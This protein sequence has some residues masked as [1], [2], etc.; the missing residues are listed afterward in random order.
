MTLFRPPILADAADVMHSISTAIPT[1]AV[2]RLRDLG[3]RERRSPRQQAAV[4]V[5]AALERDAVNSTVRAQSAPRTTPR[6]MDTPE[7]TR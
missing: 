2:D 7:R 6:L 1:E 4:L 3:R 5:L